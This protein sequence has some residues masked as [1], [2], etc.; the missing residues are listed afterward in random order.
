MVRNVFRLDDRQIISLMVPR[1]EIVYFDVQR[2]IKEI[3]QRIQ[4]S[5]HT[6]FPV[7]RGG[8]RNILGVISTRQLLVQM[9]QGAQLDLTAHLQPAVFVPETLTGMEL[10]E[11]FKS[12]HVHLVIVVDEYGE[13]QGMI[14]LEDV[15]E[16][17][18]GELKPR[19]AED[20]W[21]VQRADGSWL[22]DGL[23][24]IPELKD[25]LNL[26]HVPEE[27]KGRY[28]TLSGMIML[29]L[30]HIPQTGDKAS[31]EQ[32]EFE[33]VDI[34]GRRIDKILATPSRELASDEAA[35]SGDG[36]LTH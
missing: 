7:C 27:E 8:L 19:R 17:I 6:R 1:S 30:G 15:M 10:L 35:A 21:A 13:V 9:I 2:D 24:P 36:A 18:T 5:E 22:L 12:T 34:D 26:R 25:R 20:S 31:W 33:V 32:W 14:T 23:I 11:H 3:L 28:N 29:L 4:Q 16:A